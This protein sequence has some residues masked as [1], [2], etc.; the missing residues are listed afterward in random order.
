MKLIEKLKEDDMVKKVKRYSAGAL[1]TGMLVSLVVTYM[2][3]DSSAV[4]T[5]NA[6][7]SAIAGNLVGAVVESCMQNQYAKQRDV[8]NR[9]YQNAVEQQKDYERLKKQEEEQRMRE[10]IKEETNK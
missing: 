5:G 8:E 7:G 6:Y 1:A 10:I 9:A 3:K 4:S 2:P